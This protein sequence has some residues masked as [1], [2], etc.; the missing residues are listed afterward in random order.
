MPRFGLK[1]CFHG[2][3]RCEMLHVAF[4]Q[5]NVDFH[6]CSKNLWLLRFE[7]VSNACPHSS[8]LSV[9]SIPSI[10][11]TFLGWT[12]VSQRLMPDDQ[13]FELYPFPHDQPRCF[14]NLKNYMLNIS[15][16]LSKSWL[17]F[18][19]APVGHRFL[20]GWVSLKFHLAELV[21]KKTAESPASVCGL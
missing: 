7:I 15:T 12:I 19:P 20:L 14:W 10:S 21:M 9:L 3:L 16:W 4:S 1:M 11:I 6:L 18:L 8:Q 5:E 17:I 13:L 2:L